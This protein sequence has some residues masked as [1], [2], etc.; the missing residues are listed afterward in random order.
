MHEKAAT[1][2]T[3]LT[4]AAEMIDRQ[5]TLISALGVANDLMFRTLVTCCDA[6]RAPTQDE[7]THH[8]HDMGQ[9]IVATTEGGKHG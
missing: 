6:G 2:V 1:V 9:V 4:A 7:V 3:A 5:Q 8:R